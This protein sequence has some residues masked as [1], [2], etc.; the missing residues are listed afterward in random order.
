MPATPLHLQLAKQL[1]FA[2]YSTTRAYLSAYK[3]LLDK[4]VLTH[5]QYLVMLLGN[6]FLWRRRDRRAAA[7]D[8]ATT[9]RLPPARRRLSA[10]QGEDTS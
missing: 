2:L 3:P 10:G 4:L 6:L 7:A 9:P 1:C 5:P 8:A